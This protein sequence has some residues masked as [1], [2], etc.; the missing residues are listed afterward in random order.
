MK[1]LTAPSKGLNGG[2]GSDSLSGLFQEMGPCRITENLTS[3]LNPWSFSNA[4][5]LLFLSQPVGVGLSYQETAVGSKSNVTGAFLNETQA[6]PDGRY[7]V[8]K[9][10]DELTIDTSDVAAEA[11]WNIFQAFLSG[12]ER[13]GGKSGIPKTFNVWAESYGGHWGPAFYDYFYQQ[14]QGILNGT[15]DGIPLEFGSFGLVNPYV[16]ATI[17]DPW[18]PEFAVNNNYGIKAL[19]ETEYEYAKFAWEN[20][21]GCAGQIKQCQAAA[22]VITGGLVDG[23]ITHAASKDPAVNAICSKAQNMC[24]DNVELVYATFSGRG[25]YDIRHPAS[26]P[27]PPPFLIPFLNLAEVQNAIGVNLN[28]SSTTTIE[29]FNN[30]QITGDWVFPNSLRHLERILSYGVRVSLV[31]GDADYLANWK[32]GEALSLALKHENQAEFAAAGYQ[33]FMYGGTQYGETREYGNFSFTRMYDSGHMVPYYQR[34][35]PNAK[36]HKR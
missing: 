34:K 26:D 27:T 10:R 3:V 21:G 28:Y 33:P 1:E 19:N 4:T 24:R 17:Q 29:I 23:F 22:A 35:L 11:G 7:S 12:L 20:P 13:F 8:L 30:F 16:D 2:P 32:G 5:N 6:T 18:G 31:F 14:N 15:V 25:N 36:A 9:P